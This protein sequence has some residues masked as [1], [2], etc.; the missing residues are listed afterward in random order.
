VHAERERNIDRERRGVGGREE[1]VRGLPPERAAQ[2]RLLPPRAA[3]TAADDFVDARPL[4]KRAQQGEWL[5]GEECQLPI[6][7]IRT[8]GPAGQQLSKISA[9]A[10]RLAGQFARVDADVDAVRIGHAR[11]GCPFMISV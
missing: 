8:R 10:C 9:G 1:H 4:G 5:R 7:R 6:G 3:A 2:V 11:G